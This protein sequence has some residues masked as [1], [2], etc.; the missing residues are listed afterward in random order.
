MP[1][2]GKVPA[3]TYSWQFSVLQTP[4]SFRHEEIYKQ[5]ISLS[6]DLKSASNELVQRL[7]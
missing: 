3:E 2:E 7:F 6:A 1:A 4:A 5:N